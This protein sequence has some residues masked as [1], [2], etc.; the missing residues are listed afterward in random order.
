MFHSEFTMR[1]RRKIGTVGIPGCICLLLG[2]CAHSDR[3]G[4]NVVTPT[5]DS[6]SSSVA[7]IDCSTLSGTTLKHFDGMSQLYLDDRTLHPSS[8]LRGEVVWNTRYYLESLV[9]AYEATHN[10][11]YVQDFLESGSGV[12]NLAQTMSFVDADDATR[13]GQTVV[14]PPIFRTGWPT[15]MGTFANPVSIPTADG[16]VALIVQ[17]LY[18][19]SSVGAA[20][21]DITYNADGS[22]L[23]A[24]SRAGVTLPSYQVRTVDELKALGNQTLVYGQSPGR[25]SATGLGMPLNGHWVIDDSTHT[26]WHGEQTAGILMPFVRFLLLAKNKPGLVDGT[27][28]SEWTSKVKAI[29][30]DY[31][32][33]QFV[34]DGAGGLVIRNP[35]WMTSTDAGLYA[36]ADYAFVEASMRLLLFELLGDPQDLAISSGLIAH[37]RN[38]HWQLN[39]QGWLE[40]KD[41]P[42]VV[43]W[44]DRSGALAGSIWDQLSR[45]P[46]AAQTASDGRFF[47]DLLHFARLYH[48]T[49]E[50]GLGDEVYAAHLK[51]FREYLLVSGGREILMRNHYPTGDS[52][53]TDP[54]SL[55]DDFLV[56]AGFLQPEVSDNRFIAMNWNWMLASAKS[57]GSEPIGYFLQA[58]AKSE[59]AAIASCQLK[60]Q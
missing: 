1:V 31:K 59:S 2:A 28:I 22:V 39:S 34:S 60:P 5:V 57:P 21:L 3:V 48:R 18:P 46:N 30:D 25:M 20:F 15:Y 51:T 32:N 58:W 35:R 17:G 36:E 10:S 29:A 43:S 44:S 16:Q 8:N 55:P 6:P 13:P 23:L 52:T 37:Q 26:I 50:L 54:F 7:A 49:S 27:A 14:G 12:L 41:W 9:T 11:K 19:T 4:T 47:G 42:C 38:F 53:S 45:D 33:E 56:P 40:L 24:W